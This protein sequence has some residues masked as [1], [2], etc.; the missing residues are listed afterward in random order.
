MC[1]YRYR[2]LF[3]GHSIQQP[4]ATFDMAGELLPQTKQPQNSSRHNNIHYHIYHPLDGAPG[5]ITHNTPTADI[6][7]GC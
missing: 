1:E 4:P 5:S 6:I 2:Y 3:P 7:F